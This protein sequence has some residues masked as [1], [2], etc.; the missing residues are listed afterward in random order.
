MAPSLPD[1]APLNLLCDH[2]TSLISSAESYTHKERVR[3]VG[4]GCFP[5]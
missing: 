1:L 2:T 5:Q 4:G 3:E